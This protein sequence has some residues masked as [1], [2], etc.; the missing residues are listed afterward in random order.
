MP[1]APRCAYKEHGRRCPRDGHG[2]PPLCAPHRMAVV[3]AARPRSPVEIIA[4]AAVNFL[5]G[6]PVNRDAT[7]GAVED[8]ASQWAGMGADYRPDMFGDARESQ[9][10]RRAQAGGG[11]TPWWVDQVNRARAQAQPPQPP[12]PRLAE[13]IAARQTMGF[14]PG[15]QLTEDV[16]KDRKK[17]LARKYHPDRGGSVERMSAI[18]AAADTLLASLYDS[19]S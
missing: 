5:Q 9:A 19:G 3:E 8:I 6:K 15:D 13:R 12:D 10:H 16:I 7:I 11:A 4:D 1:R 2:N 14:A 18:N 17:M